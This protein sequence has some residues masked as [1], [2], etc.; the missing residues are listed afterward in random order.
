M[1]IEFGLKLM[2]ELRSPAELITQSVTAEER[3]MSFL[4]LSD[5]IHPWLESHE[6]SPFAWSVLG[7]IAATTSEIHIITGVTCPIVRY[8]PVIIAHAAA[9]VGVM[10]EGR[11][12]LGLGAGERLNEHVTGAPFPPV[13][14]RHQMMAEAVTIMQQ[15][16]T[17]EII[18]YRG[19]YFDA[20]HT[21]IYD[22]PKAGIDIVMAVSGEHSLDLARDTG[23][24]GI[25][26]VEPDEALIEGWSSRGGNTDSTWAEVPFAWAESSEEGLEYAKRFRFGMQG[27]A[28]AAELPMPSNFEAATQ[29]LSD[30]QIGEAIPHGPDPQA[31][32]T[33]TQAF[34]DA[35][36]TQ[37]TIVPVG[38]DLDGTLDFL[39]NE[40]KP[41]LTLPTGAGA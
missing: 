4:S 11:F 36:Y 29:F 27:W 9:T 31:Y 2:S 6:H 39:E 23:C 10:A 12:T 41:S 3:G 34:I 5:H 7:G 21:R 35:G 18:T 40:V 15:L 32:I 14:I 33:A 17:G 22:I 20:D 25:M 38:D 26:A 8:H 13:D 24:A 30:E 28:T 1:T 19:E 37:L 16:W